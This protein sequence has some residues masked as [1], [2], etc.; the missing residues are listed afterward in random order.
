M[1]GG[2]SEST[3]LQ[4]VI[5][6]EFKKLKIIVPSDSGLA[7]LKGAVM[8][9]HRPTFTIERVSKFTYSIAVMRPFD[10]KI[11]PVDK[12]IECDAGIICKDLFSVLV[13]AGLRLVV[14]EIQCSKEITPH[15]INQSSMSFR[16]YT[17]ER[18][19][20]K[21]VSDVGCSNIGAIKSFYFFFP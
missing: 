13:H 6:K 17:T 8:F 12:R 11:H 5:Q 2:Y 20:V 15:D 21:F 18:T 16:I 10:E 4:D 9:G 14:G 7:V 19:D 1:V 3:L